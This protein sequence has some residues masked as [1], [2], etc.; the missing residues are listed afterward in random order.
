M[1][2]FRANSEEGLWPT[3]SANIGQEDVAST[4]DVS[5]LVVHVVRANGHRGKEKAEEGDSD[6]EAT[7]VG[8]AIENGM[9][10]HHT[11]VGR[12]AQSDNG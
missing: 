11:A 2:F 3:S 9:V 12:T 6:G 8:V 10:F 7:G 4:F 5:R 1:K